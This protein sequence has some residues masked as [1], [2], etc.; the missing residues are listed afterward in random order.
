LAELRSVFLPNR[1]LAV[2]VEGEDLGQQ[3][4]RVPL[5]SYKTA[6]GGEAT[7]YVCERGVCKFPTTDPKVFAEQ[8]ARKN[9]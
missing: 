8:I 6:R 7:A 2:A 4:K 3:R 5:L 9:P 1:I